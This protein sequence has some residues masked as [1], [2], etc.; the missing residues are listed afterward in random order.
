MFY[1]DVEG[2][3]FAGLLDAQN[4]LAA[5]TV[6]SPGKLNVINSVIT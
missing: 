2:V 3:H 1:C 5:D 4:I 6:V